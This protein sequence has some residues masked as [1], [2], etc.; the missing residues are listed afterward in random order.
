MDMK[1]IAAI[2]IQSG[3]NGCRRRQLVKKSFVAIVIARYGGPIL[4]A[5]G[6]L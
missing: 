6:M 3:N 5:R 2:F 4:K 1:L